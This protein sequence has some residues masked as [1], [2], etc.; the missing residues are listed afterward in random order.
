MKALRNLLDN[1]K[2]NFEKGG[3]FEKLHSV[4]DGTE[5]FLFVPNHTTSKG[6]HIRDSI[7]LKRTMFTVVIALI[8][9]L[10]FG[11]WNTGHQHF[12]ALGEFTAYGEGFVDKM[13]YGSMKVIPLVVVSYLVGLGIEFAFC[14]VKGHPINEGYLVSGMLI[15]LTLPVDVP[16]WQVAV[17][18]V[19]AVVV[20]KEVFGGT[21]MNILNPALTARAFLFFAYPTKMSGNSVWVA[22]SPA[23]RES[24]QAVDGFTGAT[25]LG[26]LAGTVGIDKSS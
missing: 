19:F 17:A 13:L 8:P 21:G 5:T 24:G 6:S 4:F 11:I 22:D 2:P 7:D 1:L 9:C 3:K 26:D 20:G 14:Q 16:L 15:P 23:I 18:V 12:A 25:A 10:L